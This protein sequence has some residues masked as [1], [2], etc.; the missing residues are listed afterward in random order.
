M[1]L[2]LI[3]KMLS[4]IYHK[5]ILCHI[6][7]LEEGHDICITSYVQRENNSATKDA[8]ESHKYFTAS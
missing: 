7:K 2:S 5:P 8:E 6:D 3:H 4:H 1:N